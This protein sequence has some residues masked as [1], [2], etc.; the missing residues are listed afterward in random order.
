MKRFSQIQE[1]LG[2]FHPSKVGSKVTFKG[3]EYTIQSMT[4]YKNLKGKVEKLNPKEIIS[5]TGWDIAGYLMT[6]VDDKIIKYIALH[7]D[8]P[9]I[10]GSGGASPRKYHPDL[11]Y[12]KSLEGRNLKPQDFGFKE[13][14]SLRDFTRKII[15][16]ID[17][18]P[19]LKATEKSFLT[20]L[21]LSVKRGVNHK[22]LNTFR[23][24][25]EFIFQVEKN[26]GELLG[27][28]YVKNQD[29]SLTDVFYPEGKNEP[30]YDFKMVGSKTITVSS[31]QLGKTTNQI[32]P[33]F[34]LNYAESKGIKGKEIDVLKSIEEGS[35]R[36]GVVRAGATLKLTGFTP[37]FQEQWIADSIGMEP[38]WSLPIYKKFFKAI[39]FSVDEST[40]YGD[41]FYK[42][43]RH[44]L[45]EANQKLNFDIFKRNSMMVL[46]FKLNEE[47]HPVWEYSKAEKM[48][49]SLFSSNTRQRWIDKIGLKVE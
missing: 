7:K 40:T 31:K 19:D 28:L 44:F 17:Q 27:P 22:T 47:N 46:K 37:E 42:I 12:T 26:F 48:T 30:F 21:T 8:D 33:V 24:S 20:L 5:S 2:L 41:V 36:D 4:F 29:D 32:K 18:R 13:N 34:L 39:N 10:S 9:K 45:N 43:E 3:K 6:L 15:E 14:T 11:D 49:Y 16:S 38:D 23:L 35:V 25:P 1:S